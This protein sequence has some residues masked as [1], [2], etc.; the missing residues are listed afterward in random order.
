MKGQSGDSSIS[1]YFVSAGGNGGASE[2]GGGASSVTVA[3]IAI[4]TLDPASGN[5]GNATVSS[6]GGSALDSSGGGARGGVGGSAFLGIIQGMV[7]VKAAGDNAI[8]IAA[9]GGNGAAGDEPDEISGGEGEIGV[10]GLG[11]EVASGATGDRIVAATGGIGGASGLGGA[12]VFRSS[13]DDNITDAGT[14]TFTIGAYGGKGG[15]A[16]NGGAATHQVGGNIALTSSGSGALTLESAGGAAA[17]G[18]GGKGALE[19]AGVFEVHAEAAGDVAA[20][21]T[22]PASLTSFGADV[23]GVGASLTA[24]SLLIKAEGGGSATVLVTAGDAAG[25]GTGGDVEVQIAGD[26]TIEAA[27]NGDAALTHI[28][29]GPVLVTPARAR[30]TWTALCLLKAAILALA[31][32]LFP[33]TR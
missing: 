25:D 17:S 16:G 14:G 32:P 13:G 20:T 29:G 2:G 10:L 19:I 33:L 8:T 18:K 7:K 24:A 1:V 3:S 26:L 9:S 5:G 22:T 21:V 15:G 31:A 11:F 28:K 12:G 27:G 30:P 6:V 4:E 23:D